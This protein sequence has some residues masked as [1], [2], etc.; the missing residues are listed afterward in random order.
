MSR[1]KADK[2][3]WTTIACQICLLVYILGCDS[4]KVEPA[5]T[6]FALEESAERFN[7]VC[8]HFEFANGQRGILLNDEHLVDWLEK[9][10]EIDIVSLT[11]C[12]YQNNQTSSFI[13]IYRPLKKSV[14]Q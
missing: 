12:T 10:K 13:I 9:N 7:G 8:R 5:K 11:A 2:F 1:N 14:F 6:N 3:L 4:A